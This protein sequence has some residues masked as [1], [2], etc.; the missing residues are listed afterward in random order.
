MELRE[1]VEAV[2]LLLEQMQIINSMP[3]DRSLDRVLVR[4]GLHEMLKDGIK[5]AVEETNLLISR[6]PQ[7]HP[8]R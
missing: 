2:R 4:G 7:D 1:P 3:L 5:E 8:L 6:Y